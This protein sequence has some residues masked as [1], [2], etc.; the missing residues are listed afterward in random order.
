M[1]EVF[2]LAVSEYQVGPEEVLEHLVEHRAWSKA[3][4][5]AGIMLFSGRQDPPLGGIIVFRAPSREAAEAFIAGD[6]FTI[7]GVARY[8]VYGFT[9]TQYP[10][11]SK[12][13]DA[14]ATRVPEP[15]LEA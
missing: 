15:L 4:Y 5:D 1:D 9:P 14:F 6:P 2:F 8:R 11:R 10:W 12:E 7:Q 13:F 3:A